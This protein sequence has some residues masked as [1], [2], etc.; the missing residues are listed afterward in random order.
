MESGEVEDGSSSHAFHGRRV[1]SYLEISTIQRWLHTCSSEHSTQ[2]SS[3]G[4][5]STADPY[6]ERSSE[7]SGCQPKRFLNSRDFR[8]IDVINK[9][10]VLVDQPAEYAALS[11]VWGTS[12]RLLLSKN[13]QSML[14]ARDALSVDKEDVPKTFRDAILIAE[15]LNIGYLWVDALC[16]FQDDSEQVKKHMEI[17]ETIYSSAVLTIVSDTSS[18]NTGIPG[19]SLARPHPPQASFSWCGTTYLSARRTFGEALKSSPWERRAWCLQEKIFSKRLLVLSMDQA[20]FHC[21]AATWF[22]D[23]ILE[24]KENISGAVHMRERLTAFHKCQPKAA[25]YSAYESHRDAFGRNFWSLVKNYSKR[26]LSFQSDTI[27]A[28][29]GV[30]HSVE[31]R[32]G[33]PVWGI[34]PFM[35]VQGLTWSQSPHRMS[36]RK[37]DFPSWTWAGWDWNTDADLIFEKCKRTDAD[38]RVSEGRYRISSANRSGPSVWEIQW[39][40]HLESEYEPQTGWKTVQTRQYDDDLQPTIMPKTGSDLDSPIAGQYQHPNTLGNAEAD[41]LHH[42][43][44]LPGH[45]RSV[46]ESSKVEDLLS[47]KDTHNSQTHLLSRENHPESLTLARWQSPPMIPLR[48]SSS[49]QPH[50]SHVLRFYTSVVTV[51]IADTHENSAYYRE[52]GKYAITAAESNVRIALVEL[53]PAWHGIGTHQTV[54]YIS[55]WCSGFGTHEEDT[56]TYAYEM[57]MLNLLLVEGHPEWGE[58]RTRVQLIP[59]VNLQT[60]REAQPRW[61]LVSLA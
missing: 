1:A 18:V 38:M 6:D 21:G 33:Q 20:F 12:S 56:G 23:T 45:P 13:N 52:K 59:Y 55:R 46:H 28:F 9:C 26:M 5:K 51:S 40:H 58:I 4:V 37:Q 30:L 61:E 31:S 8:L 43:W 10:V 17:M 44:Q 47:C 41:A 53:D 7:E 57:E 19:V 11:Y 42:T 36:L 39:Y 29:A 49:S 32:Y 3:H 24:G 2:L 27:R 35:F 50:M 25:L 14:S 48:H 15:S 60:W 22:E 54:I 16:I 34:P